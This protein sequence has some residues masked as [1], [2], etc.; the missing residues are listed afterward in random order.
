MFFTKLYLYKNEIRWIAA[1][2]F[3][4]MLCLDSLSVSGNRS[5][6]IWMF[7]T[8][9]R[10]RPKNISTVA[11][12]AFRTFWDTVSRRVGFTLIGY[13]TKFLDWW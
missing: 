4:W 2:L 12:Q 11:L 9:G 8:C 10:N 6:K 1:L 5:Y 7:C 3:E 13:A